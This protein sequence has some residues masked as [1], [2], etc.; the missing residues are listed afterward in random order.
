VSEPETSNVHRLV[1]HPEA[2]RDSVVEL[3]EEYLLAAQEGRLIGVA[4]AYVRPGHA[5]GTD[6]SDGAYC[7]ELMGAVHLLS[8]RLTS[9]VADGES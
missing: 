2:A 6:W 7:G 3:L 1:T 5:I 9:T 4:I 8:H